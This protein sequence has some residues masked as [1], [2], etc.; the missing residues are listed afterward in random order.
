MQRIRHNLLKKFC[1]NCGKKK[2][3]CQMCGAT[4]LLQ[5]HHLDSKPTNNDPSNLMTLCGTCHTKWH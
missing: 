3:A 1:L 4:E 2:E 5:V